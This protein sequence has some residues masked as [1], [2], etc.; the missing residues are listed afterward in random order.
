MQV[1]EDAMTQP[2]Q[3][4]ILNAAFCWGCSLSYLYLGEKVTLDVLGHYFY[5][6]SGV[7]ITLLVIATPALAGL[8]SIA[9]NIVAGI[10]VCIKI[11]M[12]FINSQRSV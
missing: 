2:E 5:M 10:T 4:F 3:F 11:I 7:I 1:G 6:L 12:I 8:P 9:I